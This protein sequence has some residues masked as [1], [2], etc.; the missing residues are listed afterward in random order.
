[1]QGVAFVKTNLVLTIISCACLAACGATPATEPTMSDIATAYSSEYA[2]QDI[3]SPLVS[4][5]GEAWSGR[6][7]IGKDRSWLG[8]IAVLSV[9]EGGER[10]AMGDKE[11]YIH[12]EVSVEELPDG[13]ESLPLGTVVDWA[14][15]SVKEPLKTQSE[16]EPL[17]NCPDAV[18]D[19]RVGSVVRFCTAWLSKTRP[20]QVDYHSY[21]GQMRK[22]VQS[23]VDAPPH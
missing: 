16:P 7:E 22:V 5:F 4:P 21:D 9:T 17:G 12:G 14:S 23:W 10:G 6:F 8:S 18:G 11:W 19:L 2:G 1:M 13:E 15:L 20:T 3:N